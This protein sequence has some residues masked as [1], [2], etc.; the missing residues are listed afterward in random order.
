MALVETLL[1]FGAAVD[2]RGAGEWTSPLMTAL[3]FGYQD[4]AEALVRRGARVQALSAAAGIVAAT[5]LTSAHF[6]ASAIVEATRLAVR[7][8]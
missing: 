5:A 1:D 8:A 2:G 3:A 4:A 7:T 6:T